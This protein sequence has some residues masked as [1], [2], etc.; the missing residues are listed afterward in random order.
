MRARDYSPRS[1]FHADA[2]ILDGLL[3]KPEAIFGPDLFG[4]RVVI[5]LLYCAG[6]SETDPLPFSG[7]GCGGCERLLKLLI[8][9]VAGVRA[10][11]YLLFAG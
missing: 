11:G 4:G 3:A 5:A 10:E 1:A 7:V 9:R 2:K 6:L 8:C